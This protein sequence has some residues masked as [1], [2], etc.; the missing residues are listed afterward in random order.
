M[1]FVSVHHTS[2]LHS[3]TALPVFPSSSLRLFSSVRHRQQLFSSA[4]RRSL[5][6]VRRTSPSS[7]LHS[8]SRLYLSASV[9][10]PPILAAGVSLLQLSFRKD[11]KVQILKSL[12]VELFISMDPAVFCYQVTRH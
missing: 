5:S 9:P 7:S 3:S 6:V 2:S 12:G 4:S 1:Y 10:R 8:D 11:K